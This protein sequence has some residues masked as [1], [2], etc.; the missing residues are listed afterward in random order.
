MGRPCRNLQALG[1]RRLT[2]RK[3]GR[4]IKVVVQ[5]KQR[6]RLKLPKN[7]AKFLLD[8]VDRMKKET[9]VHFQLAAT[10]FPVAAHKEKIPEDPMI[11]ILQYAPADKRKVGDE[12]FPLAGIGAPAIMSIAEFQRNRTRMRS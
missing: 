9:T 8:S 5:R 6:I 11:F 10:Q 2:S 3:P 12:F 7:A 4:P 1:S